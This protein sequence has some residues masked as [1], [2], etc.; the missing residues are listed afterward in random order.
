MRPNERPYEFPTLVIDLDSESNPDVRPYDEAVDGAPETAKWA[1]AHASIDA[2]A[3]R[4][5][6]F[7]VE[8]EETKARML[9]TAAKPSVWRVLDRDI[10]SAVLQGPQEYKEP[11]ASPDW[12]GSE[13]SVMA[14]V[15]HRNGI[16]PRQT[17]QQ[18]PLLLHREE[19]ARRNTP[20]ISEEQLATALEGCQ[21]LFEVRRVLGLA[22]QTSGG[23]AA[24]RE[25]SA[26]IADKLGSFLQWGLTAP[27]TLS[28]SEGVDMARQ[29]S[30]ALLNVS[31]TLT[32]KTGEISAK[33][34]PQT[35]NLWT[36]GLWA[37]A[38]AGDI[39]A[40]RRFLQL[41]LGQGSPADVREFT[42]AW[43]PQS[44][45][46]KQGELG[47]RKPAAELALEAL[48]VRLRSSPL[49]F[50]GERAELYTLLTGVA[51]DKGPIQRRMSFLTVLARQLPADDWRATAKPT[52]TQEAHLGILS[53]E[54][55]AYGELYAA[56]LAELGGVMGLWEQLRY[57][58]RCQNEPSAVANYI[59]A[60]MLVTAVLRYATWTHPMLELPGWNKR[61]GPGSRGCLHDVR[62]LAEYEQS[63][64]PSR[65]K[66]T[67]P[68]VHVTLDP[69]KVRERERIARLQDAWGLDDAFRAQVV[70]AFSKETAEEFNYAIDYMLMARHAELE[71][72][73]A[74]RYGL[75]S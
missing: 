9:A 8:I 52:M 14:N 27:P 7:A 6:D 73:E 19:E 72:Q 36:A 12:R 41:G 13:A 45:S 58:E 43:S 35:V 2:L 53:P 15:L 63:L 44:S 66:I 4:L 62:K 16:S 69:V 17:F 47:P 1:D 23:R 60:D 31:F 55:H 65:S 26:A 34:R 28:E 59:S 51:R 42:G 64:R 61:G 70:E 32:L 74:E 75:E 11:V 25:N 3:E 22:V 24:I 33:H 40:M 10:W 49:S 18:I 46:A 21:S 71:S 67:F 57:Q 30:E 48:L 29:V 54:T 68:S 38:L 50:M 39:A 56:A 5:G 20:V 37:A